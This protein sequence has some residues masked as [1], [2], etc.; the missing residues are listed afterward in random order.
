ML[1]AAHDD[2]PSLAPSPSWHS[3]IA[4]CQEQGPYSGI[5]I[6]QSPKK[7]SVSSCHRKTS[8]IVNAPVS[9]STQHPLS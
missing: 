6:V 7:S 3:G 9:Q 1:D 2:V 5:R 8:G 4:R